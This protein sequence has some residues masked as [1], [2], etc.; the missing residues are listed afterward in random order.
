M[1]DAMAAMLDE[2]M[3][4]QRNVADKDAQ[5]MKLHYDDPDVCQFALAGLCP[6]TLFSNTKSD[7][8]TTTV[9]R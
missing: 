1:T 4:K 6:Y 3:G 8:G 5:Q 2:L 7:L 9:S